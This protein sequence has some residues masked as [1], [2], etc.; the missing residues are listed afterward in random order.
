L[1]T[2]IVFM[3]VLGLLG[4][5]PKQLRTVLEHVVRAEA[6]LEQASHGIRSQ[7]AAELDA[8]HQAGTTEASMPVTTEGS[9]CQRSFCREFSRRD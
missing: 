4:L 6:Q 1:G 7:L 2:E 8:V 5:G 3:A 9:D